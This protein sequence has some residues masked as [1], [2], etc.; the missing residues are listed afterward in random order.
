[1][2]KILT[3]H[4]A[5]IYHK[6]VDGY[7]PI[8]LAI[9]FYKPHVPKTINTVK[10]LI[11]N[12]ADINTQPPF[13]YLKPLIHTATEYNDVE[14]LR[15]LISNGADANLYDNKQQTPLFYAKSEEIIKT[16]VKN[17][18]DPNLSNNTQR[19]PLFYAKSENIIKALIDHRA[20]IHHKDEE[21]YSLIT[22]AILFYKPQDAKTIE[23]V[24]TLIRN[25][26]DVNTQPTFTFLKPLIHTA[27]EYND[28]ELLQFLIS[29]GADTNLV[30]NNQK[31][32]LFLAIRN[33]FEEGIKILIDNGSNVNLKD[34]NGD[35]P[36]IVAIDTDSR[37][38][39]ILISSGADVN[40][41][42]NS[43]ET[44][45]HL[46]A[47]RGNIEVVKLLIEI[48]GQINAMTSSME[49]PLQFAAKS[50]QFKVVKLLLEYGATLNAKNVTNMTSM[51]LSLASICYESFKT[52]LDFG[53]SHSRLV[54]E[55]SCIH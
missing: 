1:M 15:F 40:L 14:F 53:H 46:A 44:P 54:A 36:L 41:R 38:I 10:A 48:G 50:N 17:G 3:D 30:D 42:N 29:N 9:L 31:T 27:T 8:T 34:A 6:D 26:A 33:K 16:L 39:R 2:I 24:K 28:I 37:F 51:E 5:N 47:L 52:I 55:K 25:G 49:S 12:G 43:L 19:T 13:T 18:A 35:T 32:P 23:N 7:S 20:N 11:R 22:L 21:G 45:L 4:K